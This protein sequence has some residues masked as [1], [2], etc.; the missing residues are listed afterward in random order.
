MGNRILLTQSNFQNPEFDSPFRREGLAELAKLADLE[1][2]TGELGIEDTDGVVGVIANSVLIHPGFYREGKDLRIVS[3]WGVGYENVNL[4]AAT[5]SG[6]M[7]TIAPEHMVT[8]AEYA[9]AQWMAALKRVYTLNRMAHGGEVSLIRTYEAEGSALGLYGLGR[10]GQAVAERARPLLGR[11]G[12]LLVYDIRPDI[13]ELA[14]RFGAEAVDC[15]E[16]LFRE[17]DAVSLHVAGDDTLVTYDLLCAMKPHASLI[18]PSRGNLVDDQAVH[19]AIKEERLFYYIVDDPVTGPREVH[20][21]HPR[22]IC[23][24]HNAGITTQSM[25]RLDRRTFEQVRAA[26]DGEEPPHLLNPEVLEHPRVRSA[27]GG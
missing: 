4:A 6:V 5:E 11:E 10:I 8:V 2:Y 16:A 13:G 15:P 14:A 27:M 18:N 24:N 21:D 3:R 9:I 19:R 17:C 12:R 25:Q 1:Y 26:I 7:V 22:I 23:T 20:K